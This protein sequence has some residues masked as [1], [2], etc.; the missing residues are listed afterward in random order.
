M[1]KQTAKSAA[2]DIQG[3]FDP[4]GY[5]NI[6]KTWA[7]MNERMVSLA[8]ETG[9]RMTDFASEASKETLSNMRE[10]TQVRDGPAQYGKA[11][12][13]F[14]QKQADLFS[15]TGQTFANETQKFGGE[16]ADLASKAGEEET[17]KVIARVISDLDDGD[18]TKA[19]KPEVDA[20]NDALPDGAD[21]VTAAERDAVWSEIQASD[22]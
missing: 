22:A 3:L 9:T 14:M 15:R 19:G 20:I 8:V 7:S 4:K 12:T 10:V 21:P 18:F 1:A 16:T 5:E 17:G 13:D 11:Y 6:F 2:N